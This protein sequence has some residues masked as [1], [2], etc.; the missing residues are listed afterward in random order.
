MRKRFPAFNA[1]DVDWTNIAETQ[2]V[3]VSRLELLIAQH[4]HADEALVEVHRT[5]GALL[6]L[7]QV[8]S[9]IASHVGEGSI[10]VADRGFRSAVV[11]A[12]NGV[13]AG[14]QIDA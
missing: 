5:E 7:S 2:G 12:V 4:I 1:A 14:W 13:A 11:V 8:A 9:Y 10:R 6:P 3:N